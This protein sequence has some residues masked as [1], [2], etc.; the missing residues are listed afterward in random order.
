MIATIHHAMNSPTSNERSRCSN[1]GYYSSPDVGCVCDD[2]WTDSGCFALAEGPDCDI[3]RSDTIILWYFCI[4]LTLVCTAPTLRLLLVRCINKRSFR[5]FTYDAKSLYPLMSLLSKF[6]FLLGAI[7]KIIYGNQQLIGREIAISLSYTLG[8]LLTINSLVIYF[9]IVIKFLQRLTQSMS[10]EIG[11][12]MVKRFNLLTTSVLFVPPL[13]IIFCLIP[14]FGIPQPKYRNIFAKT[15]FIGTGIMATMYAISVLNALG[16][17][18]QALS[19][20]MNSIALFDEDIRTVYKRIL[21]AYGVI[22]K[23][24]F[25]VA[26]A[27]FIFGFWDFLLRKTIYII[28]YNICGCAIGST[29]LILTISKITRPAPVVPTTGDDYSIPRLFD[30]PLFESPT[31][32]DS[33]GI[34]LDTESFITTHC[35]TLFESPTV[36]YSESI[37]LDIESLASQCPN[38]A[39]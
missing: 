27:Y 9:F 35:T 31:V 34:P 20:H 14:L 17:L 6:M 18:L 12:I 26:F 4:I 21:L 36:K 39:P 33:E 5:I 11:F 10:P 8:L 3:T 7:L 19:N 1:H 15:S 29:I 25:T 2:K 24:S 22:A 28:V 30:T 13:S 37:P 32:K 16:F 38:P 23:V